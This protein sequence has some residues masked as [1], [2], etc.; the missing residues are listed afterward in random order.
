MTVG[1]LMDCRFGL[2]TE[3]N[4]ATARWPEVILARQI[5]KEKSPRR[6]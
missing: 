6:L 1:Q 4:P 3:Q 2:R 5:F